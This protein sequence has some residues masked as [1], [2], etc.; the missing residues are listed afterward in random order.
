M[1]LMPNGS[2]WLDNTHSQLSQVCITTQQDPVRNNKIA[3]P[4]KR[5]SSR[6]TL[7]FIY[8]RHWLGWVADSPLYVKNY[9][10]SGS[11]FV[12]VGHWSLSLVFIYT[13]ACRI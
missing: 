9:S 12:C 1:K 6:Q 8:I 4:T 5:T 10:S 13:L 3:R 2:A 7:C 11:S